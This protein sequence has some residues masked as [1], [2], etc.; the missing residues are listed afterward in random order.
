MQRNIYTI[1][2]R[3]MPGWTHPFCCPGYPA[4]Y[5]CRQPRFFSWQR[6]KHWTLCWTNQAN[7][8]LGPIQCN[9]C[10]IQ[11]TPIHNG[12][13]E[14]RKHGTNWVASP[15]QNRSLTLHSGLL[16]AAQT[17]GFEA[18]MWPPTDSEGT[19]IAGRAKNGEEY[20]H[21]ENPD[22][23]PV[24]LARKSSMLTARRVVILSI[25]T[26]ITGGSHSRKRCMSAKP[27]RNVS[28]TPLNVDKKNPTK[29]ALQRNPAD[30]I[31]SSQSP[32]LSKHER[33]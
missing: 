26:G 5:I 9:S 28:S 13:P 32:S 16:R 19:D 3:P 24:N 12:K 20:Q 33:H 27:R 11:F 23:F 10:T 8:R 21:T 17:S 1:N 4:P 22:Y 29:T 25:S 6:Y 14:Y 18:T 2:L 7:Y 15:V 31:K 30:H